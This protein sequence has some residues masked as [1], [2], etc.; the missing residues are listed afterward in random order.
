VKFYCRRFALLVLLLLCFTPRP[1][2]A[3][4]ERDRHLY[5][6]AFAA[7][8]AG[9]W[10]RAWRLADQA[11]DPLPAEALRWVALTH[12]GTA[13]FD[14]IARFIAKHPDWPSQRL[15][16]Q[17]AEG[18][19]AG[20]PDSTLAPWFAHHP[21]LTAAAQ[22]REA[23]MWMAAGSKDAAIE[24][25]RKVWITGD[26]SAFDEKTL[27]QRY[28]G[29]LRRADHVQ[30]LDHLLWSGQTKEAHRM[31]R[32][33]DPDHRALGEARI[34]LADM[35]PGVDRLIDRVPASLQHDPGLIYDRL[36]WRVRKEHYDDAVSLLKE[37]PAD[38]AHADAWAR[39]RQ[40]LAREML[41][42]SKPALAYELAAHHGT[43]GG[44]TFAEIEFLAGWI[45][46]RSLHKPEVAYNHFVR[47]YDAVKLPVSVGR[48]A[49]WAGRAA[50]AMH[51]RQLAG[52]WYETAAQEITT[53]YGQLA[54]AH[55]GD[56]W[57][58][59]DF[60]EPKP[61][62]E[63]IAAFDRRELVR[64]ARDLAA[65]GADDYLRP[66]LRKLDADAKTPT[67]FTL[68]ARLAAALDRPDLAVLAAKRESY[69]GVL[70]LAEGYPIA[71]LPPGGNVER[72]LVLAMTRQESAFD[73][74][75]VSRSGARGLMQLM[76]A[77]ARRV[78]KELHL[79]FSSARLTKDTRYNVTLGRAYLN[80]LI[81]D[82]SGSYVLA[83]AAYNAGP[84][85]VRQWIDDLGDPRKKG[86]DVI[87]WVESIPYPET[88]NYVQRVLENLQVYR[89]RLGD[90]GLAFSL[91][92][93]LQR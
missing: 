61:K 91:A 19:I 58:R 65:V 15:L 59:P 88:R 63:A 50:D 83:I 49:Y 1:S 85:R 67:D 25:I 22:L 84:S 93:D 44:A 77:T 37:V 74:D 73:R 29:I 31:L 78:A 42:E 32:H 18:E 89:L 57:E 39:Q 4:S 60:T 6:D 24:T 51:F 8:E 52:A 16:V 30:R 70:L 81:G 71:D 40:I 28:H 34:A 56:D 45:A 17:R 66:F 2:A 27:L 92:S 72:P 69:A 76:P 79:P 23:D 86:V 14:E 53:Y 75:A 64:V 21:P 41:A 38:P 12:G 35:D 82:F 48:G 47:L 33:V 43:V 62:P 7:A 54:A 10:H 20:V 11:H 80:S 36:R 68:V 87:D 13:S 46:L 55:L 90:H 5:H 3:L 26:F 9:D